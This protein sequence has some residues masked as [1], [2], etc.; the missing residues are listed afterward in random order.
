M[1][2][3]SPARRHPMKKE[4]VQITKHQATTLGKRKKM[5]NSKQHIPEKQAVNQI[6][7]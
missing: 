4:E 2:D 3:V 6:K 1:L 5:T 7:K